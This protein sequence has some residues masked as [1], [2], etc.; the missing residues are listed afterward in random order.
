MTLWHTQASATAASRQDLSTTPQVRLVRLI[1]RDMRVPLD[2]ESTPEASGRIWY[3][4]PRDVTAI[5]VEPERWGERYRI[6]LRGIREPIHACGPGDLLDMLD[7][8]WLCHGRLDD[9]LNLRRL[10][11]TCAAHVGEAEDGGLEV[12]P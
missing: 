6:H 3:V 1:E 8:C 5:E 10:C 12:E 9:L 7:V 11:S 4:N 2:S